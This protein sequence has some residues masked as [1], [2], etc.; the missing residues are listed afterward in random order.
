MNIEKI[1][2]IIRNLEGIR[3]YK[4]NLTRIAALLTDMEKDMRDESD[5]DMAALLLSYLKGTATR[6]INQW[7]MTSQ[8]EYHGVSAKDAAMGEASLKF[9]NANESTKTKLTLGETVTRLNAVAKVLKEEKKVLSEITFT[10]AAYTANDWLSDLTVLPLYNEAIVA[11]KIEHLR[12][13]SRA[14]V[15]ARRKEGKQEIIRTAGISK[16]D[17]KALTPKTIYVKYR[18]GRKGFDTYDADF[19]V[20]IN[21]LRKEV[22][23]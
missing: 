10:A 23:G 1:G 17:L 12:E 6:V 8:L 22:C 16:S 2:E 20:R 14:N 3:F 4:S 19:R 5:E 18:F 13:L 11:K 9:L 15:E 21:R 7:D